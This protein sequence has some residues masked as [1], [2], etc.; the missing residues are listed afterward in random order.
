LAINDEGALDS[1]LQVAGHEGL[2]PGLNA[3]TA[4][5][6]RLAALLALHPTPQ[7]LHWAVG[8]A[9]AAGATDDEIA[10]SLVTVAPI[11]GLARVNW[12]APELAAALDCRT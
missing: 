7:S 12:A 2:D 3:A 10:A 11:I 8:V 9:L 5:L 1:I 4:S 6:I